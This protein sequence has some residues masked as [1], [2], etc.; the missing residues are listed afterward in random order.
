MRPSGVMEAN[1]C[2]AASDASSLSNWPRMIGVSVAPG[3]SVFT[4]MPL[5]LSSWAQVRTS[6]RTPGIHRSNPTL[7]PR[8]ANLYGGSA[9]I[10]RQN[11]TVDETGTIGRQEHDRLGNLLRRS[12][13][14]SRRLRRELLQRVAHCRCAFG[15]GW[16]GTDRI[17]ADALGAIFGRPRFS[18]QIESGFAR[19][20]E[21]HDRRAVISD[22]RRDIDDCSFASVRHER[23]KLGDEEIGRLHIER[24][25]VVK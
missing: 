8:A 13:T 4:R 23:G 11:R 16:S 6:E 5:S 22:H 7:V 18:Q 1:A 9:A 2:L 25:D 19:P 12:G 15:A 10:Y 17:Y 14:S 20:I 3:L 21:A 24:V